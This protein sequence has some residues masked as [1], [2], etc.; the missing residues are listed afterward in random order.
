MHG[1]GRRR[2]RRPTPSCRRC[3]RR[4]R[5]SAGCLAGQVDALHPRSRRRSMRSRA[6]PAPV[7]AA[8]PSAAAAPHAVRWTG[9]AGRLGRRVEQR[10]QR[11]DH[12]GAASATRAVT[13]GRSPRSTAT[14][15]HSGHHWQSSACVA[16]AAGLRR[17]SCCRAQSCARHAAAARPA[18]RSRPRSRSA[19][20]S[21]DAL[22]HRAARRSPARAAD[23]RRPLRGSGR[24]RTAQLVA[25]ELAADDLAAPQHARA[26]SAPG[27]V[28][29]P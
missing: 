15:W 17:A 9:A 24:N 3:R 6:W 13:S 1:A 7:A 11:R 4:S 12:R 20:R 8:R 5:A 19:G 27:G 26:G 14:N 10:A 25:V 21:C 28:P 23:V 2:R 18:S 16:L 29:P 22:S